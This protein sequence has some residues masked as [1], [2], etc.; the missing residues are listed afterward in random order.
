[1]TAVAVSDRSTG[2]SDASTRQPLPPGHW[3]LFAP[4]YMVLLSSPAQAVFLAHH[5][6]ADMNHESVSPSRSLPVPFVIED[7]LT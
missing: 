4:V 3:Q 1:M 5:C 2:P 6:R 7:W